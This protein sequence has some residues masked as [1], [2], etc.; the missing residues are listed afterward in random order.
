VLFRSEQ[1]SAQ[2]AAAS[3]ENLERHLEAARN[4]TPEPLSVEPP[5][6]PWAP[7]QGGPIDQAATAST[8]VSMERLIAGLTAITKLPRGFTAHPRAARQ[9]SVRQAMASGKRPIDWAAAEALAFAT[10]LS[11]GY[12]VRL[13]GQDSERGTFGH[14]HAVLYDYKT[15]DRH[16]PL[17]HV[18]ENQGR[19]TV[20]NSPLSEIGVLGF[21]Y[22]YSLDSPEGLVIWEAQFG[23]FC[24]VAQVIID[25]FIAASEDKWHQLT[26]L[27]LFLPHGFEGEGPEHS[28]ARLERFLH[29]AAKDN[30]RVVSLT[31]AGQLFHCLRQQV[32]QA[33][34]KPLIVM[35]PKSLLQHPAAGVSIDSLVEGAFLPVIGA[36]ADIDP[37]AT[38]RI[39]LCSG[40]IYYEVAKARAN[41]KRNDIALIRI[42][43]LYPFP[44]QAL[45]ESLAIFPAST[46]VL[47]IQEEPENMGAWPYL[48]YCLQN[49]LAERG[50]PSPLHVTRP[51]S[52]S[53]AVGSKAVHA[54]EQA[55]LIDQ[56]FAPV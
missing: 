28:S 11:E 2:I 50:R 8:R 40:K 22:G 20:I 34:R 12:P 46:P 24:N 38:S 14:R 39:V 55:Q 9:L 17:E 18:A 3:Q 29:L 27:C 45:S 36:E 53:P 13:S 15:E 21:E 1:E 31:T 52:A 25:Q 6:S 42:E 54:L 10:L 23:D 56:A 48:R 41:R 4:A 35:S 43:Q 19:F 49:F 32:L 37:K 5:N 16:A 47:W 33:L 30:M 44:E 51:E 7:Y 26:G